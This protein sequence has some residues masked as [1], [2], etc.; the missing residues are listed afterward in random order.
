MAIWGR[1]MNA[2]SAGVRAYNEKALVPDSSFGWDDYAA[3]L[4][5]YFHYQTYSDNTVYS[6]LIPYA[7]THRVNSKLYQHTRAIYNPVARQNQ[8]IVSNVYQ[9]GVDLETMT[10]GALP[11]KTDNDAV[12]DALRQLMK[13]S[14]LGQNLSLYV[15]WAALYGDCAIKVVDDRAGEKVRLELLHPG[16]IREAEFDEVGNV[17][18]A[19]IEYERVDD[20]NVDSMRPA[21]FGSSEDMRRMPYTYTEKITRDKFQ[22]FKDG[23]L[24]P[25]YADVG[26]NPVAEWDNEYGFVPLV[27]AHYANAGMK[28]GLNSFNSSLRK[29][30]EINDAASLINDQV[31]KSVDLIWYVGGARSSGQ[32]TLPD[33]ER[34]EVPII[35]GPD[36]SQ[37]YPMVGNLPIADALSNLQNMLK[38]LERDMPELALQSIRE[39]GNLTA[40]GVRTG[41][42]D[43]IGNIQN[44]RKNLDPALASAMQMAI[45][46]GGFNRYD[47]FQSFT[48]ESYERGDIDFDI[49]ER[50][51]IG[52]SLSKQERITALQSVGNASPAIQRLMLKE[53]DYADKEIDD[54]IAD[55]EA[56]S[57]RK[58]QID[59]GA[60]DGNAVTDTMKRLGL[61]QSLAENEEPLA[62]AA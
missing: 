48:L 27:I 21:R 4:F 35:Y 6:S 2:I 14:K 45:S 7:P 19:I 50:P 39:N 10:D 49:R 54:V 29:I 41:Y 23:E 18:S 34:D 53:L 42:S 52:D 59:F 24:F 57:R 26:G 43:A 37:P 13:W 12:I 38:E 30:D 44:A 28:W 55:N 60:N 62:E 33:A 3:R 5:R 20:P 25:F 58:E 17:K 16:K 61:D 36:G 15:R 8:L 47:G 56:E 32:L 22:T 40:P 46:I 9:G 31:R 51:V 1:L 11:I